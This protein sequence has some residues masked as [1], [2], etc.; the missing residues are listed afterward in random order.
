M[1]KKSKSLYFLRILFSFMDEKQKLKLIKYNKCLQEN[2]N[3]SLI[4]Y[5]LFSGKYIIYEQNGKGK[6]YDYYG[7]LEFEGEYLNGERNGKGK[8]YD[9]YGNLKFEGEYLNGKRNG[10]GKEYDYYGKL[11]FEG[12]YLNGERNGKWCLNY[13]DI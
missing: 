1:L 12:E 11:K 6:E 9:Y 3:I 13:I 10:K 2:M 7:N 4:N 8:E 5:R